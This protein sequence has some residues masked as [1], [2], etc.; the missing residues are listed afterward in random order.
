MGLPAPTQLPE[1][2]KKDV[3]QVKMA[4]RTALNKLVKQG[5]IKLGKMSS[6]DRELQMVVIDGEALP[7]CSG[8][9]T[10]IPVGVGAD[11]FANAILAFE[12]LLPEDKPDEV[13][14]RPHE[15]YLDFLIWAGRGRKELQAF[16][17]VNT[18]SDGKIIL[19]G[20]YEWQQS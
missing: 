6:A 12:G 2:P 18:T 11:I 16:V 9:T 1:R 14:Y 19:E 13:Y 4:K 5:Y 15:G 3:H 8:G 20:K 10:K 7:F 17:K